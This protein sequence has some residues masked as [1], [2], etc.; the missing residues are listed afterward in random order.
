MHGYCIVVCTYVCV[1]MDSS[2]HIHVYPDPLEFN[3]Q[4]GKGLVCTILLPRVICTN[5][6]QIV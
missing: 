6:Q 1:G 3:M 5:L 2:S 4:E